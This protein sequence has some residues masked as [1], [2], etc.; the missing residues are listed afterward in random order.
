MGSR[1]LMCFRRGTRRR[2][3][4]EH[5]EKG[6]GLLYSCD[7]LGSAILVRPP[8]D[9]ASLF[10]RAKP[11]EILSAQKFSWLCSDAGLRF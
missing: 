11:P 10:E 2:S 7:D 3:D 1:W 4:I 9:K 6:L 5:T 8:K